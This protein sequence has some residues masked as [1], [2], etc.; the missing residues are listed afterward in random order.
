MKSKTDMEYSKLTEE[1]RVF[2]P[3]PHIYNQLINKSAF[4]TEANCENQQ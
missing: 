3:C 1:L 2:N 4:V